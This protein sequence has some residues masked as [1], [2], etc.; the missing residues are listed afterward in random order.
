M[1]VN[2]TCWLLRKVLILNFKTA[3]RF[4]PELEQQT[5]I[6]SR[7][8]MCRTLH[9]L[10]VIVTAQLSLGDPLLY[11]IDR[12]NIRSY[13]LDSGA[14]RITLSSVFQNGFAMDFHHGN[15]KLY[16]SDVDRNRIYAV[17][18]TVLPP[19]VEVILDEGIDK[20]TDIAVDWINDNLY[21]TDTGGTRIQTH[22]HSR[23]H[24]DTHECT[25]IQTHTHTHRDTHIQTH[26]LTCI[27]THIQTQIHT[28]TQ[29]NKHTYKHTCTHTKKIT[30]TLNSHTK[31]YTTHTTT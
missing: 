7:I 26:A 10:V 25:R 8:G 3:K 9:F 6:R 28:H 19:T 17:D 30:H 2:T 16:V 14:S 21:W 15:Q 1:S 22:T 31:T 27:Q 13:D 23:M 24:A 12:L 4:T 18:M 20:A 5:M 29:A 11:F